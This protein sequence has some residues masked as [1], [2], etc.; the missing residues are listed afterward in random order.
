[1]EENIPGIEDSAAYV[2]CADAA[3][4]YPGI[5]AFVFR[6]LAREGRV[7]AVRPGTK[8]WIRISDLERYM[9]ERRIRRQ[10]ALPEV[11]A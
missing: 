11:T 2:S 3:R 1:M 5:P 6:E 7:E 8:L 10:E 9:E 4:R